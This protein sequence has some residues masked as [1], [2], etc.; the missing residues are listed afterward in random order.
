[1][2]GA[3]LVGFWYFF[4]YTDYPIWIDYLSYVHLCKQ[5][6]H[7]KITM[8]I[9]LTYAQSQKIINFDIVFSLGLCGTKRNR[10]IKVLIA[11]QKL[12]IEEQKLLNP[13]RT[14]ILKTR[15]DWGGG[16]ESA[17]S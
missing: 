6:Y 17:P 16:A 15:S 2:V 5:L 14:G 10:I 12:L 1:M 8:T 3:I 13:I 11:E 7:M 9:F 4:L